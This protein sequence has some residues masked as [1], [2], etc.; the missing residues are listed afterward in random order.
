MEYGCRGSWG[1]LSGVTNAFALATFLVQLIWRSDDS[2]S[3]DLPPNRLTI[4]SLPSSQKDISELGKELMIN[5]FG[6]KSKDTL[7]SLRHINCTKKVAS[8]KASVTPER[9]SQ[10]P[11]QPYSIAY[12]TDWGWK[13]ESRQLIPVMTEKNAAPDELLKVIH[14]N[15]LAEC[16][17]SR[18]RCWRYGLP[19]NAACGPCQTENCDNP[20][21]TQDIDIE[22][23]DDTKNLTLWN[24]FCGQ[25][26]LRWVEFHNY[27]IS[28]ETSKVV[29]MCS[30]Y[31]N[32]N[33][34]DSW[35]LSYEYTVRVRERVWIFIQSKYV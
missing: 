7:S 16:K 14:C 9:L 8:A 15:C 2:V 33:T 13:E 5:L 12:P 10:L 3:L 31:E 24:W 19:C 22:E 18:C 27:A 28:S 25:R 1:S 34:N 32:I 20:N 29:Q 4:S 23:K 30:V 35:L 17:S 11:L 6:G 26:C 21:N